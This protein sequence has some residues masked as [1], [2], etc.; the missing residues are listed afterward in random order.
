MMM[1]MMMMCCSLRLFLPEVIFFVNVRVWAIT[2]TI[3]IQ[4]NKHS[5]HNTICLLSNQIHNIR[6]STGFCIDARTYSHGRRTPS[7]IYIHNM[8]ASTLQFTTIIQ[9]AS[10]S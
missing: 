2:V 6:L 7:T 10:H 8:G 9:E 3:Y 5:S 1:M 4:N